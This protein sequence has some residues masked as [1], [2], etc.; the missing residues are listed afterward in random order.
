VANPSDRNSSTVNTAFLK[1]VT[2]SAW[3]DKGIRTLLAVTP[4]QKSGLN[5]STPND[6]KFL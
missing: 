2:Q 5:R 4:G 3:I 6:D 1:S